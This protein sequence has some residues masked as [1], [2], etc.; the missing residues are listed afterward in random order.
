M[1]A[2]LTSGRPNAAPA[3]ERLE[4]QNGGQTR[5]RDA[6][7]L[8]RE[9]DESGPGD[10]RVRREQRQT[11]VHERGEQKR[12]RAEREDR[13]DPTAPALFRDR[14]AGW[15]R[16]QVRAGGERS[17]PTGEPRSGGC[18]QDARA[19]VEPGPGSVLAD[20]ERDRPDPEEDGLE[21]EPHDGRM[22][23][24]EAPAPGDGDQEDHGAG[25]TDQDRRRADDP[26]SGHRVPSASDVATVAE[27]GPGRRRRT[28][29]ATDRK[30]RGQPGVRRHAEQGGRERAHEPVPEG[31][32]GRRRRLDA[33]CRQKRDEDEVGRSEAE[34]QEREDAGRD[35]EPERAPRRQ[36]VEGHVERVRDEHELP[37]RDPED[38]RSDE[39]EPGQARRVGQQAADPVLGR[40]EPGDDARPAAATEQ[41]ERLGDEPGDRSQ[42]EPVG[43][44]RT[45]DE[46]DGPDRDEP[47][48][49]RA[50]HG[51]PGEERA[52]GE[53]ADGH[54][55]LDEDDRAAGRV[56]DAVVRAQE[57][58]AGQL[59]DRTRRQV[60]DGVGEGRHRDEGQ[61]RDRAPGRGQEAGRPDR[62]QDRRHQ[63]ER[64]RGHQRS[65]SR[66][67]QRPRFPQVRAPDD[68]GEQGQRDRAPHEW[69]A[70][71]S[72]HVR[73]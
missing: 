18:R 48:R 47:S 62:P 21:A 36:W 52:A 63:A 55:P 49:Q 9:P 59:A 8:D 25:E 46:R 20:R 3:G 12:D 34:R 54:Q 58:E 31:D 28:V 30:P 45:R 71:S 43:D 33:E 22:E 56:I 17:D 67:R 40:E 2:Q 38:Q 26:G 6:Q 35:G 50:A 60:V 53:V 65:G 70:E 68:D 16:W 57:V 27:S 72:D 61:D 73:L 37:R 66:G 69:A 19:Q 51:E 64:E 23:D 44:P 24:P 41:P 11:D 32:G 15:L 5:D 4:Q 1:T 42:S 29:E 7:D 39:R 13:R 14:P 10:G